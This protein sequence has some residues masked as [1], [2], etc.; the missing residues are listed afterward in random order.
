MAETRKRITK[1]GCRAIDP[2]N[3]INEKEI[4]VH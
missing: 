3:S 1:H 2:V 4:G